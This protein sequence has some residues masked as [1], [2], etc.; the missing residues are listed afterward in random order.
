MNLTCMNRK[1][2][3]AHRRFP[4]W[5]EAHILIELY[6]KEK[7]EVKKILSTWQKKWEVEKKAKIKGN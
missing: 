1:A 7:Q 4:K 6:L 3:T 2:R 5:G